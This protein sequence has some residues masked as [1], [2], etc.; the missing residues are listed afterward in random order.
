[1]A[2]PRLWLNLRFIQTHTINTWV[3][4]KPKLMAEAPTSFQVHAVAGTKRG[5]HLALSL[6]RLD[7]LLNRPAQRIGLS[8]TVRPA[9]STPCVSS[10]A[11]A[12]ERAGIGA[13]RADAG[14]SRS[15]RSKRISVRR[16]ASDYSA[17]MTERRGV[18][19]IA[20]SRPAPAA[21]APSALATKP[22][23]PQARA[24]VSPRLSSAAERAAIA[25]RNAGVLLESGFQG[26]DVV[27]GQQDR[28]SVV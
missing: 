26:F 6:E 23:A 3:Q 17:G 10:A 14:A 1:M 18:S 7:A 24:S 28:K 27:V 19:Q 21:S 11:G 2:V 12:A 15:S 4:P 22:S 9:V 8:A 16:Q 13:C 25:V 5:A 20:S